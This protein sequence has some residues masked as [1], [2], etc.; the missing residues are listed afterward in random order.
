[1]TL[2][3]KSL[4]S[5]VERTV[6]NTGGAAHGK[7]YEYREGDL[8][9]SIEMAVFGLG[10]TREVEFHRGRVVEGGEWMK[11]KLFGGWRAKVGWDPWNIQGRKVVQ[12]KM[13]W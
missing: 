8:G 7:C 4:T 3:L 1:M 13:S 10:A 12:E 2:A 9:R 6:T 11:E 5:G